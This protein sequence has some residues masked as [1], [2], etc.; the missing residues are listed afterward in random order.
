M[1]FL[2]F[3]AWQF[4]A[5]GAACAA[6]PLIIHLLNRRRYK[7]VKWAA[8]DFL[9]QA[10]QRN[11]RIMQI[12]DILLLVL[13]TAAVLLFGLAL[14]RPYFATREEEFD[15]RQPLHAVI[16]IDNS[17]S[18]GYE[19]LEGT[20]L[21]KAKDRARQLIDKLP[22]GSRM[23]IIPVCG[24]REGFS[25]D[26]Y[27]TKENAAEALDK[28]ELVDRSASLVRAANEAKRACEAAPELAKRI[29]FIGDQQELNWQGARQS[30]VLKELPA[31]Q[32]VDVGPANWEN[33]WIAD[34]RVQ[35]GLAD[36][37]TPATIVVELAHRGS[38]PRRDLLVTLTMGDPNSGGS[39][40]GEKTVTL[41]PG[42]GTREVDF[43]CVFNTL[44]E[45]PEPNRPVFVP[46]K[47]TITPDRL[48]ADDQRFLAVP[49]VAALPV[50]FVDQYGPEQEDPIKGRL[51]E[52]RHLRKLLAP[53]TSRSD[54][55]RQ[56]VNV[57]HI[58][59]DELT[60]DVLAD[61]RLLVIAGLREPG[62]M[63]PLLRDYVGQGGQLVI[64]AGA[65]FD[66]VAWNDAAWL[67]GAGVLPLPLAREALGETPE[68]AG[69]N[70][71][72]FFLSFDS[73]AGEDYFHLAGVAEPELRDLYAEPFFFK[74][75]QVE[76]SPDVL[77][78]W[79][80]AELKRLEE[81]LTQ[82]A[83]RRQQQAAAAGEKGDA[84]IAQPI[85][86]PDAR[87]NWLAWAAE[88]GEN[89]EPVLPEEPAQRQRLLESLVQA[90]APRVLARYDLPGRPPF[91]V[92]RP[93]GRGEVLFCS[94]GLLSSWNTLPKTNAVLIFD[95]ILR[96]L[97]QGTLPRRNFAATERLALPL[98][99]N[100]QNL[101]VTLARPGQKMGDEPLD[102]GYIG[103]EQR[104]VQ[105][106]GLFQRGIY[107]V[108]GY[109][110]SLSEQAPLTAE[111]PVWDLPLV[112]SGAAAESDLT[113]LTR[114][115]FEE[116]AQA[117]NLRWIGRGEE[118][119][120]AGTAISGQN[121]WWWLVLLVLVLLLVE[122][123]VLA[124]PTFQPA[125]PAPGAAT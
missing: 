104:G 106:Q 30:E 8:M 32:I 20:L 88:A 40:I 110:P 119:N 57:R 107:R 5:V 61:A 87:P 36:I 49:V 84:A 93:I 122:M 82:E 100:E 77:A 68:V 81:E 43:E 1:G 96:G 60:R 45:L 120:L 6:G 11:R 121:S 27:E 25:P 97:T 123:S 117:A 64:V 95:R 9:R 89:I 72:P 23:S 44:S 34:L 18:M 13:R 86:Q 42:L 99:P 112:V 124:W 37:E 67:G 56:L 91:L 78:A 22:A 63:V 59:Q 53:K 14:A 114:T 54:A 51:G 24:S 19:S 108:A 48:A 7:V 35:D 105:V 39:V 47:A 94:T 21:D 85:P 79:K 92:S 16:L 3:T 109:R 52:T 38:G 125:A 2:S 46:L 113:A 28:I 58:T 116:A 33:T 111:K 4:A 115:Q 73:L 118:I 15:D 17:L 83:A 70:L 26:P 103:P 69:A 75:V 74:S 10:L 65:D 50:V 76:S 90:S 66:P 41:E 102:V 71:K 12:R 55:P 80:Q 101:V 31:M 98:P 29:V 62:D